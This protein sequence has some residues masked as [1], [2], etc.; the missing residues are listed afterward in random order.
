MPDGEVRTSLSEP[1]ENGHAV[2]A[3]LRKYFQYYNGDRSHTALDDQ[4][5]DE[6]YS[7]FAQIK[8]AA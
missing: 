6:A 2:E 7:G 5:P 4:T 8:K 1:R 3:G